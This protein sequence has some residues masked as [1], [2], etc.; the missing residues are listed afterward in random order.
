MALCRSFLPPAFWFSAAFLFLILRASVRTIPL[1]A[2]V[3]PSLAWNGV[4]KASKLGLEVVDNL[5]D[6]LGISI[7]FHVIIPFDILT[8]LQALSSRLILA[9]RCFTICS[10]LRPSPLYHSFLISQSSTPEVFFNFRA[11]NLH[12]HFCSPCDQ[13]SFTFQQRSTS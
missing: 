9:S 7:R 5:V 4:P 13:L 2:P 12:P 3:H 10:H 6:R 8:F 1:S 11:F